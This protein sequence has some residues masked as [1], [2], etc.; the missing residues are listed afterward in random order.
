[1][2]IGGN[3]E[4][5]RYRSCRWITAAASDGALLVG[6]PGHPEEAQVHSLLH[7]TDTNIVGPKI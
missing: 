2:V 4:D 6:A 7:V 1:M 5:Y 3:A